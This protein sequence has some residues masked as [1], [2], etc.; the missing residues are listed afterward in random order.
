[1]DS[2]RVGAASTK[3]NAVPMAVLWL[4]AASAVVVY[5]RVPGAAGAFEPL[6]KWQTGGGWIA[7]FLSRVV[8][9]GLVPGVFIVLLK[10]LRPKQCS[11]Y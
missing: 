6:A 11:P 5:Y 3:A 2:I 8:F 4:L 10:A 7:A 9:C 1:M